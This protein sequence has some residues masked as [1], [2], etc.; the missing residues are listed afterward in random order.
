MGS[1]SIW[2]G[3][4]SIRNPIGTS[5]ESL[6]ASFR[7]TELPSYMCSVLEVKVPFLLL[8]CS[9]RDYKEEPW[10]QNHVVAV[11]FISSFYFSGYQIEFYDKAWFRP[12]LLSMQPFW[13]NERMDGW[14]EG[15]L[16]VGQMDRWMDGRM[17][18]YMSGRVDDWRMSIWMDGWMKNGSGERLVLTSNLSTWTVM[19][20]DET[21]WLE[22]EEVAGER[23]SNS[24]QALWQ[25]II[26]H[27]LV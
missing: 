24:H 20:N 22:R 5:T 21:L 13:I 12:L 8:T 9:M 3:S 17:R 7:T 10:L 27:H 25:A 4:T 1:C 6:E 14:M 15:W 16:M 11:V 19:I 18:G 23:P 26:S 2:S